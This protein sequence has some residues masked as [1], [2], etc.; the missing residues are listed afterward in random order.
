MAEV[1][2]RVLLLAAWT[3]FRCCKALRSDMSQATKIRRQKWSVQSACTIDRKTW[4]SKSE[5]SEINYQSG[6]PPAIV[7]RKCWRGWAVSQLP[8][9][10]LRPSH[11]LF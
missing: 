10:E 7:R 6:K 5:I 8:R 4:T 2:I 11:M 1:H 3:N 9:T